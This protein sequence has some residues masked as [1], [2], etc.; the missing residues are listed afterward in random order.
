MAQGNTL[1]LYKERQR[2]ALCVRAVFLAEV[3]QVPIQTIS[4]SVQLTIR[5]LVKT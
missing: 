4:A 1:G 5:P 3:F 2:P